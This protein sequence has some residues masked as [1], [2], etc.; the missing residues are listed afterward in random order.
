MN[1]G[2]VVG[3]VDPEAS[4]SGNIHPTLEVVVVIQTRMRVVR[5]I[6]PVDRVI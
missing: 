4:A 5:P 2:L 1:D 3:S 6:R